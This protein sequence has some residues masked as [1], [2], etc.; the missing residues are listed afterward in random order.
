MKP[1]TLGDWLRWQESLHPREIE[2]GLDRVRQVGQRL[3]LKP[4]VGGVFTV[5]GTN[6]KGS[7]VACLEAL[8]GGPGR[9]VGAYTSPHLV[10]YNE[11][12]CV[13]SVPCD[14]ATLIEAF[15][16]VAGAC[17]DVPLTYFEFGTLSAMLIFSQSR[18]DVWLLE[19]GLGG[20]LDAVN[21]DRHFRS[22]DLSPNFAL[23][24]AETL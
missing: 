6:G 19:V 10:R 24:L 18:C 22:S 8:L 7:T 20:R 16:T 4:P 14:D 1:R 17:E 3:P 9:K 5:A 13:A 21:N 2:L 12:V 15:A 11:R 23:R